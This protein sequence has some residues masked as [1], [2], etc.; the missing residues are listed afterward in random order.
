VLIVKV[1]DD[2]SVEKTWMGTG[3]QAACKSRLLLSEGIRMN[4]SGMVSDNVAELLVKII[5]F[6]ISRHRI[7]T[8][9]V[10]NLHTEGFVP[11][12]L[13]VDE[14]AC[15]ME[16]A[17]AEHKL[18]KRLLLCDT[19]NIK[20]GSNGLV[21]TE[22]VIDE[23]ARRLLATDINEYLEFQL[24]K[25]SENAINQKVAAELLKQKQGMLSSLSN[26]EM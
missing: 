16:C 2:S 5:D 25:L 19:H 17:I 22:A 13:P 18:H 21:A 24:K 12:D 8:E 23:S 14:F 4:V 10:N 3:M 1:R 15:L 9:N 7:L 20:F 11:R 6:T 26:Y